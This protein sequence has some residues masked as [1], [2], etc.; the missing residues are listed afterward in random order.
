[1][2]ERPGRGGPKGSAPI[3]IP[4][5]IK[6]TQMNRIRSGFLA[7]QQDV[8]LSKWM[9]R[10]IRRAS[11]ESPEPQSI[12]NGSRILFHFFDNTRYKFGVS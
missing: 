9:F 1:M 3:P 4:P 6:A 5:S 10:S 8:Q 12:K 7:M 2:A 11:T